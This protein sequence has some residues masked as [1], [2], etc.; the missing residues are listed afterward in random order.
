MIIFF[1]DNRVIASSNSSCRLDLI[2]EARFPFLVEHVRLLLRKETGWG[3]E[4]ISR[5]KLRF[6]EIIVYLFL[7][8]TS[9]SNIVHLMR[10]LALDKINAEPPS[11]PISYTI[12]VKLYKRW[13]S[14]EVSDL[15]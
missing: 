6:T 3:R 4:N 5:T 11:L 10:S 9:L 7:I 8:M 13:S 1:Y 15:P 12:R 14:N 2:T